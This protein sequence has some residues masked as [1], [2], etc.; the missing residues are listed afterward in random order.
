M[1][2]EIYP[3]D[4]PAWLQSA[5]A[6][7]ATALLLDVREPDEWQRA[8]VRPQDAEL[9]QMPMNSIPPRL[10]ELNPKRPTAVLCHHGRRSMQV[11]LFLQQHGFAS[12]INVAGGI[13]AWSQQ[14][15]PALP[16]Y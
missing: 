8:S 10:H 14:V 1:I 2:P 9:L 16:R 7:G 4:L 3:R 6:Q 5:S 11:A 15:D 12:V 13:D